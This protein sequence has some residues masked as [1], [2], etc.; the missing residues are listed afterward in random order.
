MAGTIGP[1]LLLSCV[2]GKIRY[3]GIFFKAEI[4][5]WIRAERSGLFLK[6]ILK[7]KDLLSRFLSFFLIGG[8]QNVG[9]SGIRGS[10]F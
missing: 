10:F 5:M 6:D 3:S 2:G 4:V 7:V 1:E 9:I 8:D